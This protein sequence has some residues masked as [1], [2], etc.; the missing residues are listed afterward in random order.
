VNEANGANGVVGNRFPAHTAFHRDEL[1]QPPNIA[2]SLSAGNS[3][4]S[5]IDRDTVGTHPASD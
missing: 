3:E 5:C 1:E 4:I 2:L